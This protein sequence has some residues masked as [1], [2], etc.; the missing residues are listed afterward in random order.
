MSKIKKLKYHYKIG[1]I[2]RRHTAPSNFINMALEWAK[3][4]TDFFPPKW[5]L[6][7]NCYDKHYVS[8]SMNI[9]TTAQYSTYLMYS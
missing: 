5:D 7:L 6:I 8:N 3:R 2:R 1:D 9:V 4:P